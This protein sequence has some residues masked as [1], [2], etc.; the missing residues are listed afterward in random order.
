MRL[1]LGRSVVTITLVSAAAVLG[2]VFS[3]PMTTVRAESAG[4]GQASAVGALFSLSPS[5]ELGSHFCTASVVDSPAGDL[6]VTAAHCMARYGAG[7]VA[8]VPGYAK[9]QEPFGVWTVTQIFEDQQWMSS[10]DPDDDFAFLVVRQPGSHE[11]IQALT[12]GEAVGIDVSAGQRVE[13]AGY[14]DLADAPISCA[15]T[16]LEFSPTQYEFACGGFTDGTSGS[17]LLA[18]AAPFHG[19]GTVI[20]VIGGY[21]QG[22]KLASV[23]Y[24]ARFGA[25][26]AALYRTALTA[27]RK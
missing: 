11:A 22:G 16:A 21:E 26:L 4:Y 8:F 18:G 9:G 13:V 10:R 23:S 17:P 25:R 1:R 6:I 20:G 7:E 27:A 14:P 24:A 19:A 2:A 3:P 15:N 12:G 5:G